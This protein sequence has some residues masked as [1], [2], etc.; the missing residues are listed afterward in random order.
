MFDRNQ[1]QIWY[2]NFEVLPA[3]NLSTYL[4]WGEE[5]KKITQLKVSWFRGGGG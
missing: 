3:N 2:D 5:K 1:T 4:V